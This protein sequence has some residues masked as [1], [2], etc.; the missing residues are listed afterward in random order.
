MVAG[1]DGCRAGWLV[2]SRQAGAY[3]LEL[4]P[5]TDTDRLLKVLSLAEQAFIDMAIG[6]SEVACP[7]TCDELVRIRLGGKFSS[8]VFNLPVRKAL[9]TE[10]YT[11]ANTI[12]RQMSGKGLSKQSWNLHK[13]IRVMDRLLQEHYE[14]QKKVREAHPELQFRIWNGD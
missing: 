13:K 7:R 14:L 4:I 10:N 8:S 9:Y 3:A 2:V 11:Q 12:N 6:V 1:I 5:E